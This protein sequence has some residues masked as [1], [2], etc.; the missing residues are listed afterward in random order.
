MP[1]PTSYKPRDSVPMCGICDH[2]QMFGR[3]YYCRKGESSIV[4]LLMKN[5]TMVIVKM[6][7]STAVEE[8]GFCDEFE[9]ISQE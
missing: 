1:I 9:P 2:A 3:D 6:I 4:P 7:K 5:E 8:F